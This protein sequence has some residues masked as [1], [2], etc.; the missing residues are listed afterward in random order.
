MPLA[1]SALAR[2][3]PIRRWIPRNIVEGIRLGATVVA[4]L[5]LGMALEFQRPEWA[6]WTVLSVSLNT[7][8]SSLQKSDWRWLSSIVG[9]VASIGFVAAFAQDTLAFGIALALW[10]GAASLLSSGVRGQDAYGFS[11]IG[12]TVP[13]IALANVSQPLSVFDT[14]VD[15][16]LT[17]LLGIACA[18]VSGVCVARGVPAARAD[19]AA[20]MGA[21]ARACATWLQTGDGDPPLQ[22]A[23]DMDAAV[24]DALVEHPSLRVG[25]G[26]MREAA[27]ALHAAVLLRLLRRSLPDGDGRRGYALLGLGDASPEWRA[28]RVLA[29]AR[30]VGAGRR[31]G[32]RR[33][34]LPALAIDRDWRFAF[35][36]AIR[37]VSA[38]GL[39]YAFWYCSEWS[40]G[41]AAVTWVGVSAVLLANRP[42]PSRATFVFLLGAALAELVGTVLH[43]TVLTSTGDFRLLA[44]VVVPLAMLT[45][46][47]R[48]NPHAP[49]ANSFGFLIFTALEPLRV[50]EYD[51][52]A[53]LNGIVATMAGLGVSVFAFAA[54][55]PPATPATSRRRARRRLSRGLQAAA[56]RPLALLPHPMR[57]CAPM[58][59]RAAFLAPDGTEAVADARTVTLAG[60]LVLAL[61]RDQDAMGRQAGAILAS[62]RP[63]LADDLAALAAATPAGVQRDRVDALARLLRNGMPPGF[64]GL[65]EAA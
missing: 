13:I 19:L 50:M 63:G 49:L 47:G 60:L 10:L 44:T 6:A 40:S 28:A 12:F 32:L 53:S 4:A 18:Y 3:P 24:T 61:R 55:P 48:A 59:E 31:F 26:A 37:T 56:R 1:A 57:W 51:L 62:G 54:L 21:A 34:G 11:L 5:Y 2:P 52:G 36:N 35:N 14:A 17:L 43:Y 16:C 30:A 8:A 46:I 7:R 27:P 58:L 15:R 39:V 41:G 22:A 9:A 64:P 45:A 29:T 20:R 65:S 23:L 25:G 33:T 38:T 42:D